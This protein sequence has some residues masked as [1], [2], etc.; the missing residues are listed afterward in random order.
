[1]VLNGLSM[2]CSWVSFHEFI[3]L[4][5]AYSLALLSRVTFLH[6]ARK[7]ARSFAQDQHFHQERWASK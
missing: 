6:H 3:F 2:G 4:E 5:I 7:A 1:M